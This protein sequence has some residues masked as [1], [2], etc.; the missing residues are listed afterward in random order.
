MAP[1]VVI[2]LP[3]PDFTSSM[4]EARCLNASTI[5]NGPKTFEVKLKK[6]PVGGTKF[7]LNGLSAAIGPMFEVNWGNMNVSV[8]QMVTGNNKAIDSVLQMDAK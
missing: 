4:L 5:E 2:A 8:N 7:A 1:L 3:A 6:L